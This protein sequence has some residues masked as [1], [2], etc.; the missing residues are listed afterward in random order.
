LIGDNFTQN[1]E[2]IKFLQSLD[3]DHKIDLYI[4]ALVHNDTFVTL[5]DRY[6]SDLSKPILNECKKLGEFVYNT[7]VS[8]TTDH[9]TYKKLTESALDNPTNACVINQIIERLPSNLVVLETDNNFAS[10]ILHDKYMSIFDKF[11]I[12]L[13]SPIG[14]FL[15]LANPVRLASLM[16][17]SKTEGHP[18]VLANKAFAKVLYE[19]ITKNSSL[20][21]ISLP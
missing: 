7:F 8:P 2:K 4:L 9:E 18:S 20:K 17:V 1:Y 21:F 13:L 14:E 16:T 19:E 12:K 10:D 11:D 15:K 5:S 3:N 6:L